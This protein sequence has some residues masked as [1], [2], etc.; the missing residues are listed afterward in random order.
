[1]EKKLLK[2]LLLI[3]SWLQLYEREKLFI[4]SVCLCPV[5]AAYWEPK[6]SFFLLFYQQSVDIH[7]KWERFF[8]PPNLKGLFE[9]KATSTKVHDEVCCWQMFHTVRNPPVCYV[10]VDHPFQKPAHSPFSDSCLSNK[11]SGLSCR[12]YL[13]RWK[14]SSRFFRWRCGGSLGTPAAEIQLKVLTDILRKEI[15]WEIM[16]ASGGQWRQ[17]RLDFMH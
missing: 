6:Y 1:M 2:T 14:R 7:E 11:V 3:L 13:E 15:D 17:E 9:G 16:D 4:G 12:F 10:V 5:L 8:G